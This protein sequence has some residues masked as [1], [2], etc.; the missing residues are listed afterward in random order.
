MIGYA[1]GS[2]PSAY[3]AGFLLKKLDI[4]NLGDGNVGAENAY[5]EFGPKIGLGVLLA[6]IAKG[7]IAVSVAK[8]SGYGSGPVLVAGIAAVA[9]HAWPFF[10]QFKGGRG[11]ATT[12]GAL[13]VVLYPAAFISV[14]LGLL[15]LLR[16]GGG[17]STTSR[18]HL[19]PRGFRGTAPCAVTF[20]SM[21]LL[22]WI[23][24]YPLIPLAYS[25]ALPFMVGT[26]HFS[27]FILATANQT[28]EPVGLPL[29]RPP[30]SSSTAISPE[31]II[32]S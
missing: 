29:S 16:N 10:L 8:L 31:E 24:G 5:R 27:Q 23:L 12:I 2:V 22:A 17:Y 18:H 19:F 4:R 20:I 14:I 7:A 15:T 9:G 28:T 21:P 3:V 1:L 30:A 13:L 11:A 25:V 26:I 32:N 6:D